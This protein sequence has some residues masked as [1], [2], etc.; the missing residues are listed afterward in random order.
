MG[1]HRGSSSPQLELELNSEAN[2]KRLGWAA[3]RLPRAALWDTR[4]PL[5][6]RAP[7]V[8]LLMRRG[9]SLRFPDHKGQANRRQLQDFVSPSVR[10]GSFINPPANLPGRHHPNGEAMASAGARR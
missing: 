5:G 8:G 2:W 4:P 10:A 9:A 6:H 3:R 7:S 1:G